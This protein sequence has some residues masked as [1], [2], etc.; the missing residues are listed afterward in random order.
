[1]E[2]F[3]EVVVLR[4]GPAKLHEIHITIRELPLADARI[5]IWRFGRC[6]SL[7]VQGKIHGRLPE[8]GFHSLQVETR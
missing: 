6:Q 8:E 7:H 4:A 1:M 5:A 2:D 3:C